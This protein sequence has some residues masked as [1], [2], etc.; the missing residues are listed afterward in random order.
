MSIYYDKRLEPCPICGKKAYVSHNIVDGFEFGWDAGCP[1]ACLDDGVHG[2]NLDSDINDG[3]FPRV[4][5]LNFKEDA[6]TAWN[7]WV[8]KY[9]ENNK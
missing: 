3:G 5:F 6:I 7:K 4:S 8:E 2:Y 1:A 9:K